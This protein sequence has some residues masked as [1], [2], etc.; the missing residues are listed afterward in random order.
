MIGSNDKGNT[1][2]YRISLTPKD[3]ASSQCTK[4]SEVIRIG[5]TKAAAG[6]GI[7]AD[8]SWLVAIGGNKAYVSSTMSLES[9][10]IKF[11]S[12]DR[13]TCLAF[14]PF[15]SYFATGDETGQVRLWYCLND[16][17][18]FDASS[19]DEKRARTVSMHWHAHAVS[20]L[21]FTPNGSYLMSG[22]EES[23]LVIWQLHSGKREY[24]PR[25]GAPILTVA[26][27][28]SDMNDDEYLVGLSDGRY[29]FIESATLS[30]SRSVSRVRLGVLLHF[31][32]AILALN[33]Q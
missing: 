21:A 8:G 19:S 24:V 4:S 22:G 17:T 18:S 33:H 7:S 6:L 14:H 15:E 28:N 1:L 23:V 13:L 26:I 3:E 9:G 25:L 16:E 2:V 12:P 5:K 32:V 20:A 29:I 10:F 30:I 27:R 11:V 31:S